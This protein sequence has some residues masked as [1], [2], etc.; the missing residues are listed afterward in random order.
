MISRKVLIVLLSAG[1]VLPVA[2][3][4]LWAVGRLLLAMQDSAA[5]VVLDRVA[6]SLGLVW[7]LALVCLVLAQAI[8]AL[9]P[10]SSRP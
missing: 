3:T 9:G 6:L 2:I 10:P 8:N 1:C 7:M 5:A 4:L